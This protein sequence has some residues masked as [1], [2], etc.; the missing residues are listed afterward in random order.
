MSE[1]SVLSA[2]RMSY[3]PEELAK[4]N[5]KYLQQPS[6]HLQPQYSPGPYQPLPY[7]FTD[8]TKLEIATSPVSF[9]GIDAKV[10]RSPITI[11]CEH[12]HNQVKSDVK[13]VPGVCTYLTCFVCCVIGL[14]PCYYYPFCIDSMQDIEH[15]CAVCNNL[16]GIRK[17]C[18]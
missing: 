12:C 18:A 15:S 9:K 13:V 4:H 14:W 11:I 2:P 8:S 7:E 17:G 1:D 16:L 5:H 3:T 10:A 6:Q